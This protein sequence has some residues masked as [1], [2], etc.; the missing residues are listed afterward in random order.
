MYPFNFSSGT[1]ASGSVFSAF[2]EPD[3]DVRDAQIIVGFETSTQVPSGEGQGRYQIS[4]AEFRIAVTSSSTFTY[5]ES[6]DPW[7]TTLDPADP[8][9]IADTDPGH[10][11]ELYGTG[12]RGAWSLATFL[13]T[14]PFRDVGGSSYRDVRNAFATDYNA[15]IPRDISNHTDDREEVYPFAIGQAAITPGTPVPANTEFV[16]TF[17]LANP[18]VVEYLRQALDAGSLRLTIS[19]MMPAVFDGGSGGSGQVASF[20]MREDFFALGLTGRL[21]LDVF[22]GSY[23]DLNM[24]GIV[25]GSDLGLLL[26]NWGNP[27]NSDLNSDGDTNGADLGLLLSEWG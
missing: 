11:L 27:G 12:F 2:N 14:S 13:E 15:R 23:A 5:D 21:T 4:N 24:D 6:L 10:P 9:Y 3:F 18:D 16:F 25:D 8:D 17:D 7:Q 19:S 22:V 1:R 20:Y 26:G